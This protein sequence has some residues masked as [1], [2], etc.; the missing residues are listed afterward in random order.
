MEWFIISLH[1][2]NVQRLLLGNPDFSQ[3]RLFLT[4]TEISK[5]FSKLQI[6]IIQNA[7]SQAAQAH[8]IHGPQGAQECQVLA[9]TRALRHRG[10]RGQNQVL[11]SVSLPYLCIYSF[12]YFV[13][14]SLTKYSRTYLLAYC[15]K[16]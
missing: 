8:G 9:R 11:N 2:M 5:H 4:C 10:H 3:V 15:I 12:A 13:S 16:Y 1:V 7:S 14:S 6:R